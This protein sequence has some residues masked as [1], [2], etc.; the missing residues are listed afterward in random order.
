MV[1]TRSSNGGATPL[2]EAPAPR[3]VAAGP[4]IPRGRA[5]LGGA[6]VALSFVGMFLAWRQA[7]AD[8][9]RPYAVAARALRP[10]DRVGP[11]D[12]RFRR[13]FLPA[14]AARAAF[15]DA[16]SLE[17]RV[18]LAPVAEGALLEDG[19]LSDQTQGQPFAEVSLRLDRA[20]AVD[21]RVGPGDLVDVYGSGDGGT[22]VVASGIRVVDVSDDG[23]SFA[24]DNQLTVTL[25]VTDAAV[26]RA[27]IQA[28]QGA[29]VTLVRTTHA[30]RPATATG[31]EPPAGSDWGTGAAGASGGAGAPAAAGGTSA[32][33]DGAPPSEGSGG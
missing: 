24:A 22:D 20:R 11:G 31:A 18:A 17:G 29:T 5:L 13:M 26:Q 12:V 14:G 1:M 7:A 3:V 33:A 6:L 19:A 4:G 27:V 15:G 8:P 30:G 2:G 9:G 16:A 23:G 25:A 21:G 28:D 10:G 32:A